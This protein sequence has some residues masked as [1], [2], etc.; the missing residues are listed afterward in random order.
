MMIMPAR[1]TEAIVQIQIVVE[2]FAAAAVIAVVIPPAPRGRISEPVIVRVIVVKIGTM[3]AFVPR[4]T[5]VPRS[6]IKALRAAGARKIGPVVEAGIGSAIESGIGAIVKT[7]AGPVVKPGI[8]SAGTGP[9]I[10]TRI[11]PLVEAWIGAGSEV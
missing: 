5:L 7:G 3:R 8:G 11:G 2:I 4:V 9:V 6:L 1:V 10:E